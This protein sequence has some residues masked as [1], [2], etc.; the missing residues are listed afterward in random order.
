MVYYHRENVIARDA[1]VEDIAIL[2]DSLRKSDINE[3]WA[4]HHIT[5]EKALLTSYEKTTFCVTVE[6][7]KE[8]IGMMGIC[9][10]T[11]IGNA[12]CIWMLSS[13]K[14]DKVRRAFAK[15]SRKYIK[16]LLN[17]YPLLYNWV[18]ARNKQS[19]KWLRWCGAEIYE[20]MPYGVEQMPFYYFEFRR[21]Q[22]AGC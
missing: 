15:H 2:K 7:D 17:Q 9:P 20:A 6:I 11:L 10:D 22:C 18:D 12:A 13:E 3:L 14:L 4:S 5:P 16:I 1:T 8:P 19:I 21:K